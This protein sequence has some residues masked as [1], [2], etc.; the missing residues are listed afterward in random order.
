MKRIIS[1][2]AFV[3]LIPALSAATVR[4]VTSLPDLADIA[5]QIGRDR[6]KVDFIVQGDQNPHYVEVKPSYMM[7][8]K[9]ADVFFIIGME[10]EIWA[11]QLVDGSRN[12]S[13]LVVDLSRDIKKL[14][15][16]T[17][18]MDAS[19]GD[20]HR[21]GNPH[22]WLDPRNIRLIAN[23]MVEALARISPG[24]EQFFRANAEAYLKVLDGKIA[25]WETLM[26]PFAGKK[27]VTFHQSWS[28]LA[29]W[30]GLEVAAQVE[31]KPGIP[32]SP[33]HTAELLTLMRQAKIK[34]VVVEP[35]YDAT[36]PEQI[37]R[38]SDAKVLRLP[39]SVGGVKEAK[40]YITLMDYDLSSLAAAL[41]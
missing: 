4:V 1:I 23:E 38:S 16:P 34:A 27:I 20:V 26:K 6:V 37:A 10:L 17:R 15:V 14:E 11:P 36:A 32:P 3:L 7:K 19:A 21:Y 24:D 33:T 41:R 5:Q 8:L 12:S 18:L 31:P 35:F 29:A 22:Y 28:Y 39:T 30:T 40:D 25:E 2:L 13:L 9:S